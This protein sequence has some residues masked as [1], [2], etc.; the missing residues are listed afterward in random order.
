VD[1]QGQADFGEVSL[2]ALQEALKTE[3]GCVEVVFEVRDAEG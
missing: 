1:S 2:A 3:E